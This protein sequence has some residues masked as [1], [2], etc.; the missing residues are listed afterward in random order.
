VNESVVE[1]CLDVADAEDVL[2]GLAWGDV[3]GSVVGNLLL[4][5]FLRGLLLGLH[6]EKTR[7]KHHAIRIDGAIKQGEPQRHQ[8]DRGENAVSLVSRAQRPCKSERLSSEAN[9]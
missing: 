3:G 6:K 9:R 1:R 2:G 8:R 4:L 7:I 5:N